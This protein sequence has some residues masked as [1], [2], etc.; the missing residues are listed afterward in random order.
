M[1]AAMGLLALSAPVHAATRDIRIIQTARESYVFKI[2]LHDDDIRIE[3][4]DGVVTLTGIV[5]EEFHK[6]M[7]EITITDIPGV[8]GMDNRLELKGA[9]PTANSD[10]WLRNKVKNT[11]LFH[12]SVSAATTEIDVKDGV[13]TLRGAA[14]S[15]AQ[16]DLTTEYAK[17]VDGAKNVQNEMT[18]LTTPEKTPRTTKEKIDDVSVAAL[19][20]MA[21]LLHHSTSGLYTTVAVKR[22]AVTVEG[23]AK[24]AA[25]KDLVTKVVK[26]VNGVKRVK[27]LMTI[28]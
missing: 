23:T 24:T 5:S 9:P 12:R 4:K 10:A 15:Q 16:R 25:E 11:L 18:V 21:L 13:V 3:S 6:S 22:G 1:A 26:D 27:N 2:Y 28:G 7:A 20:R 19:V 17:D 14:V 8:R